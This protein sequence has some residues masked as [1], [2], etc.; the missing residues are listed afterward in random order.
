VPTRTL[1]LLGVVLF[2]LAACGQPQAAAP[3]AVATTAPA[4]S[5]VAVAETTA[6][7]ASDVDPAGTAAPGNLE[8]VTLGL[9]YIPNVQFAPFYVAAANGYYA[10]EG[11]DVEFSYGGNVNDLLLQT[12]S[13]SLPFVVASGDEVLLARA[14]QIPVRMVFLLYQKMPI[15]VFS[16]QAAGIAAPEDLRGKTIGLPGRYGATYIGL[17]GLLHAAGLSETDVTLSEIGFAQFEAVSEDRVPAAVGYANN[18]PLRMTEAGTEVNVIKVADYI[19]LVNNGVIVSEAFAAEQP[20]TVRKFVRATRKGLEATLA[21]PDEAFAAALTHIPELAADR[22]PFERKVLEETL[23]YWSTPDTE[24]E[25]LGWL[26]P[27]AWRTTYDFL[28]ETGLLTQ[29]TDP[30]Q[31][32]SLEFLK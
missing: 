21:N 12:A 10:D 11:L 31:A 7:D 22:Q 30:D 2:M 1:I 17:R 15:A 29:E 4:A 20:E 18:E 3:A 28:R 6:P 14:Q 19:S 16:K 5:E 8:K 32:Y 25:G 27:P 24:R 26:N 23:D 9:G 13:G